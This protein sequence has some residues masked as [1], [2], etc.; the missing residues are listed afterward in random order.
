M[1][2]LTDEESLILSAWI[3]FAYSCEREGRPL[4]RQSGGLSTL[5]AIE[6]YLQER[7][8]LDVDGNPREDDV[9]ATPP[10]VV[11]GDPCTRDPNHKW[12]EYQPKED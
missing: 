8:L 10:C 7:G 11:G 3:Q 1:R 5:E 9:P 6:E 12:A 4:G 2:Q